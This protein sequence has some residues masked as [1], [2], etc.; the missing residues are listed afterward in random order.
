[1]GCTLNW[2]GPSTWSHVRPSP[3]CLLFWYQEGKKT[4]FEIS[5]EWCFKKK[6]CFSVLRYSVFRCDFHLIHCEKPSTIL[7]PQGNPTGSPRSLYSWNN[8]TFGVTSPQV[9]PNQKQRSDADGEIPKC[10]QRESL[11]TRKEP[12]VI[13]IPAHGRNRWYTNIISFAGARHAWNITDGGWE[14]GLVGTALQII[15]LFPSFPIFFEAFCHIAALLNGLRR[16]NKY[17]RCVEWFYVN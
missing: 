10:L 17:D 6:K 13:L 9:T 2:A 7:S 14:E 1:M 12:S 3:A 15:H 4:L 11:D 5:P 16:E 8:N